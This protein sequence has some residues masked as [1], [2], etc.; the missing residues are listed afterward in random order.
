MGKFTDRLDTVLD[1]AL[2]NWKTTIA[3]LFVA[4]SMAY[5]IYT[6]P[7]ALAD[8]GKVISKLAEAYGAIAL[9]GAKD[10]GPRSE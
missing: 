1:H 7:S 4:T 8:T 10:P 6:D 5:Q 2:E 3:G 9:I